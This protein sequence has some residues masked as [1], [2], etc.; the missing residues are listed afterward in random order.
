MEAAAKPLDGIR[1]AIVVLGDFGRSPRM[2]Y[3]ALACAAQGAEVAV[4]ATIETALPDVVSADSRISVHA[5]P[6]CRS[7]ARLR[8]NIAAASLRAVIQGAALSWLLWLRLRRPHLLIIQTPPAIPV[9]CI[10]AIAARLRGARL[11]LDWHN[12]GW[13][14]LGLKTDSGPVLRLCRWIELT[15]ARGS[16]AHL[17]VSEAMSAALWREAPP[18]RAAAFYDRPAARFSPANRGLPAPAI[19]AEALR[20]SSAGRRPLIAIA[21]GSWTLD[22]DAGLLMEAVARYEA[23]AD[24]PP[25]VLVMSGQGPRRGAFEARVSR[26]ALSRCCVRFVWVPFDEYPALLAH[27]DVGVSLHRSASAVDLPMKIADMRGSGLPVIA[28]EYACLRHER[29]GDAGVHFVSTPAELTDALI[30][31]SANGARSGTTVHPDMTWE[32]EWQRVC[33]PVLAAQLGRS[34]VDRHVQDEG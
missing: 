31:R 14:V 32:E 16:H 19:V 2:V 7:L 24:A 10:A 12:F 34:R 27:A 13:M 11:I 15:S 28:L 21:P 33:L 3:H 22:E 6:L 23:R 30:L 25:L 1:V 29:R 8:F 4:V 5:L 17:C 9:V 18:I 26:M 20:R